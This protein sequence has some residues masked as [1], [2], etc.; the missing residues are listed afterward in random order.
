MEYFIDLLACDGEFLQ[1]AVKVYPGACATT[2]VYH[3]QV[4]L[5]FAFPVY[6]DQHVS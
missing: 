3:E 5:Q 1:Y 6:A 4:V 2:R